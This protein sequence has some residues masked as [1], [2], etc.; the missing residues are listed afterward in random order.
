[1]IQTFLKKTSLRRSLALLLIVLGGVLLFLAP[2]TWAGLG[3]LAL[4]IALEIAGF[5]LRHR[6]SP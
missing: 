4:G 6:D 5:T 1:M 3:L 2:E